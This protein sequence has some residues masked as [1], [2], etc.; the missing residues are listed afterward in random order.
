M[1]LWAIQIHECGNWERCCADSFWECINKIFFAVRFALGLKKPKDL[2][3]EMRF[4]SYLYIILYLNFHASKTKILLLISICSEKELTTLLLMSPIS[5]FFAWISWFELSCCRSKQAR[6]QHCYPF[7]FLC[8]PPNFYTYGKAMSTN[9][10][11]VVFQNCLCN[12]LYFSFRACFVLRDYVHTTSHYILYI[13]IRYT[14]CCL[15]LKYLRS[16]C[17]SVHFRGKYSG[18]IF[19]GLKRCWLEAE[20]CPHWKMPLAPKWKNVWQLF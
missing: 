11:L 14:K 12:F 2:K 7:P 13:Y 6:Y 3:Y 5:V 4:P 19:V 10:D 20:K 1:Y 15:V 16:P 17:L 8:H 18:W 9:N